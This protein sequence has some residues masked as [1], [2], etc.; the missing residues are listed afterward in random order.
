MIY[1]I[2]F[3]KW[4]QDSSDSY[5]SKINKT[6][7]GNCILLDLNI[8]Y[9]WIFFSIKLEI[10]W[11]RYYLKHKTKT[12][13]VV[14]YHK[15]SNHECGNLSSLICLRFK[16]YWKMIVICTIIKSNSRGSGVCESSLTASLFERASLIFSCI[17]KMRIVANIPFI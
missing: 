17:A 15:T 1:E 12:I 10:N 3:L 11:L 13:K 16:E 6:N 8:I 5:C 7:V 14:P 9:P 4:V 2:F